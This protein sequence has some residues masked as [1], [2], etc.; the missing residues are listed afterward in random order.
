MPEWA[1]PYKAMLPQADGK[2]WGGTSFISV[3]T[4]LN[5]ALVKFELFRK[6][7]KDVSESLNER[8]QKLLQTHKVAEIGADES[9]AG[10]Y[11]HAIASE[12][13][14]YSKACYERQFEYGIRFRIWS[15]QLMILGFAALFF[16]W[17][18]GLYGLCFL[19]PVLF[20]WRVKCTG[21]RDFDLKA[22]SFVQSAKRIYEHLKSQQPAQIEVIDNLLK[23][24]SMSS[25]EHPQKNRN[26][27]PN[28]VEKKK[29]SPGSPS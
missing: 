18:V 29:K 23:Q 28:R 6:T 24:V 1:V 15:I 9:T 2:S 3:C 14:T 22:H 21:N 25:E 7:F 19:F 27:T 17:S 11:R 16:Q 5:L 20:C 12:F 8:H 26:G 4:G 10:K 13:E